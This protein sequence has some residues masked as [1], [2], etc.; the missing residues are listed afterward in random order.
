[1]QPIPLWGGILEG[2]QRK[3]CP[4]EATDLLVQNIPAVLLKLAS[5]YGTFPEQAEQGPIGEDS[6]TQ[7][8][9]PL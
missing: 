4:W 6:G 1:M 9:P 5:L 8:I 2:Q 7:G 3:P